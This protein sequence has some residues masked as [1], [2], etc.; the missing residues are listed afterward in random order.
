VDGHPDD[1]STWSYGLT[2]DSRDNLRALI[3]DPHIDD[4]AGINRG[5]ATLDAPAWARWLSRTGVSRLAIGPFFSA[6]DSEAW[7]YAAVWLIPIIALCVIAMQVRRSGVTVDA[8]KVGAAAL[9]GIE[10]N[11]FLLRGSLDSRLPDVVVPAAI[12]GAWLLAESTRALRPPQAQPGGGPHWWGALSPGQSL[13][14]CSSFWA[15]RS[16]RIAGRRSDRCFVRP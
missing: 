16:R 12:V 7:L 10:L 3:A 2:D 14:P 4:T 1:E 8:I 9:V 15:P 11:L 6:E 5:A 13:S